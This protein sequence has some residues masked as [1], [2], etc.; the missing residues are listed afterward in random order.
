M[1][2]TISVVAKEMD[3]KISVLKKFIDQPVQKVLIVAENEKPGSAI[4]TY[5][6]KVLYAEEMFF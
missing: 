5:F 2:P 3:A 6:D 1:P 4:A